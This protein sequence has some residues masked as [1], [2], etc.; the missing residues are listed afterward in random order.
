MGITLKIA[1]LAAAFALA[2]TSTPATDPTPVQVASPVEGLPAFADEDSFQAYL[3]DLRAQVEAQRRKELARYK[4]TMPV[5]A[6]PPPPAPATSVP[7]LS[8][9]TVSESSTT[10]DTVTMVGTAAEPES[11][12]NNQTTGVD[13]GDIVKRSGDFLI[14]LRRGR[15]FTVRIGDDRLVPVS[16][17][18][19]YAP[20]VNPRSTWY[21]EMLVSAGRVVVIG[22]SYERGGTEIGLFDLGKD[23]SLGYR[24][25]YQLRGSDYYS[26]SNYAS[27]LVGNSLIFYTPVRFDLHGRKPMTD[28]LPAL[29]RWRAGTTP[30]DFE[31]ILPANRIHRSPVDVD[32]DEGLTLH[33]VSQCDLSAPRMHCTSTGVL[34]PASRVFYVSSDAV[35]VWT[36]PWQVDPKRPNRSFAM[37]IPFDGSVPTG[38]RTSGSPI[39]QMSFL[40]RDGWLNVLVGSDSDGEGMWAG[41]GKAGELALLRMPLSAFG[42]GSRIAQASDY[43]LLPAIDQDN[44]EV[45]NRFVG[46]WLLFGAGSWGWRDDEGPRAIH[47]IRYA[48]G[49]GVRTLPLGHGVQRI[50]ALGGNGIVIGESGKDLVF[51]SLRLG[52]DASTA[53]RYIQPG[54]EQG[55][56]RTHGFFYKPQDADNGLLGLP[57]VEA[58]GGNHGSASVLFLRNRALQLSRAGGL[59]SRSGDAPDDGC[60]ASCVDWYGNARPIFIGDRVF[61]LLGYE[62]V[63]GTLQDGR[64]RERRRVDFAPR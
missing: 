19:A 25:T 28:A 33:S 41:K 12:T 21:D 36:S 7:L 59:R 60:K 29:R 58:G 39:D 32:P 48:G 27:R 63:E 5:G 9:S 51:T 53:A 61:A 1:T 11:I 23:G 4:A 10:L 44:Y 46:D 42:N 31:R 26:A 18:D 37:R 49:L 6:P 15:L 43:R 56:D 47:A 16:A 24:D 52:L 17:V 40:Q 13:E 22:Y 50:D 45:R 62:L 35:Y 38:L 8:P 55:D 34:G 14:V 64:I 3:E 30:A 57:I 54:A 2:L 20:N